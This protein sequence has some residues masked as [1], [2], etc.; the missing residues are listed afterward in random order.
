[1]I[2]M[3]LVVDKMGTVSNVLYLVLFFRIALELGSIVGS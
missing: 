1:M 3:C 2:G